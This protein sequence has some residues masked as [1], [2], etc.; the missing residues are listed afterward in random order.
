MD[1]TLNSSKRPQW[2]WIAAIWTV[3]GLFNATQTVLV[4]RAEGMHHAWAQ[5]FVSLLLSWLPWALAT[6]L[7]LRLG[8]RYAPFSTWGTHLAACA[9]IGL[10]SAAWTTVVEKLL[11]PWATTP[12]PDPFSYV[13]LHKFYS[14][15]LVSLILYV[16]ILLVGYIWTPESDWPFS[17]LKLRVSTNSSPRHASMLS[18]DKS[19]RISCSIHSMQLLAW[20]AK[21]ETTRP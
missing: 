7:V 9:A 10:V 11:H 15:L 17:K 16:T 19:S 14:G 13:W 21:S 6:P 8:C 18:G 20:R 4:M 12:D 3:A 2:F 1:T 5:L